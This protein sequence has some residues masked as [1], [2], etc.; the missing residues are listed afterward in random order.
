MWRTCRECDEKF[1][2]GGLKVRDICPNCI[3]TRKQERLR[4]KYSRR[5][6]DTTVVTTDK[7]RIISETHKGPEKVCLLCKK[8][9][10]MSQKAQK[11]CSD[12][13]AIKPTKGS[14]VKE[15][16]ACG[17]SYW[18]TSAK[19]GRKASGPNFYETKNFYCSPACKEILR[20]HHACLVCD[21]RIPPT[22]PLHTKYCNDGCAETMDKVR[23]IREERD[24]KGNTF[25]AGTRYS[26]IR[27]LNVKQSIID[28]FRSD[29]Y[30]K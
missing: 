11:V 20:E 21:E 1:F 12:C 16:H 2:Q 5:K 19:R 17:I 30:G 22:K 24:G 15:C 6:Y 9:K 7:G 10:V 13:L 28:E 14:I 29:V 3:M 23:R 18:S 27:R 26:K 25:D 8:S 4:K